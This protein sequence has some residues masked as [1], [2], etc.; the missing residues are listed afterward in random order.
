MNIENL[1]NYVNEFLTSDSKVEEV[2]SQ[3]TKINAQQFLSDQLMKSF[4]ILSKPANC[5][6]SNRGV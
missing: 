1:E 2:I 4:Q 5:K 6:G 3:T